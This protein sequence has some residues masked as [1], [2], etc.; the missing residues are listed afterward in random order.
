MLCQ[1]LCNGLGMLSYVILDGFSG[2]GIYLI[3]TLQ[4]LVFFL[5]RKFEKEEPRWIYPI[6]FA[7]YIGCSLITFKEAWDLAPM[8]AALFCALALMQKKSSHYRIVILLNSLVWIVYDIHIAA[9]AMLISHIISASSAFIGI[10][11]IDILK[12]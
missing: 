7:A 9:V 10:L 5:F 2:F 3:A 11:R 6:I 1:L 4:S 8:I 12:K